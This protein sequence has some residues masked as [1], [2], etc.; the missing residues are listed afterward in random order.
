MKIALQLTLI[1]IGIFVLNSTSAQSTISG[2]IVSTGGKPIP[3]ASVYLLNTIDGG[4]TDS[5]GLFS[6]TTEEKGAQ[7]IVAEELSYENGGKPI[8][9]NGDVTGIEITLKL[10]SI[11]LKSVTV[12]AGSFE[13]SGSEGTILKPLD[14]VTTAGSQADVVK[15]IQTL[16]GTQQQGAQTGLFVRGGDASEAAVIIDGMV[17]QNAFLSAAPG[18][19]A[20]SRFGPFQFKGVSFSSGGYSARYGQA[21][22]SVLELNSNDQPDQSTINTGIN[23]AGVY[24]A[25]AK[26]MKKSSIEGSANYTNL[27]P[28][29]GIAKTNFDFYDVPKGGGGSAKYTY[30]PNENGIFKAMVNY[31]QFQNGT[32]VPN[33]DP[34]DAN[35]TLD[36]GLKN[37]NAYSVVSYKQTWKAKWGLYAAGMYSYNQ[38]DIKFNTMPIL[39]KDDRS[40]VRLEGKYFGGTKISVLLGTEVQHFKYDR[41]I[42][43]T[44][45]TGFNETQIAGYIEAEWNP[46]YWLAIKP[47]MR[48][49]NSAIVNQQSVSP[50]MAAAL[51]AGEHGQFSLASG[52]F[53]QLADPVYYII[54]MTVKPGLQQSVHYIANYQ[55]MH[56]DRTLRLEAYYK[57]YDQLVREIYIGPKESF[58]ANVNRIPGPSN[59]AGDGYAQ[60]LELFWRDKKTVKNGDYWISYS[61]IDTRRLYKNYFESV[62][63]DFIATHNL[64]IVTKYFIQKW[65]TQ[66][67]ATYNYAS[68]RP[69]YNPA[70]ADFMGDRAPDFHNLSITINY[71][72]S[73]GKWFS[74]IYAGVDNITNSKNVFGYR[75]STNPATQIVTRS[76]IV[77]P[78]YRSVF[79]GVNFSLTAFDVDEL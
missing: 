44:L 59:N 20:R 37:M 6:F 62:Q 51:R 42:F 57:S 4:T 48:V 29:Y 66:I 23:M 75:Y 18:V 46:L 14:I 39:N 58:D 28:F 68:G 25:A 52:I 10:S 56:D 13:A 33:P 7:T 21:L 17:A 26:L 8:N 41:T 36:F 70:S 40:Q 53:Y 61:Y 11:Q 65:A 31:Q 16:P 9:I 24:F 76:P 45:K 49:E 22:S 12:T 27:T 63:P 67:N 30:K 43:D 19:A 3:G 47:G 69:Y 2:R 5:S 15:A 73:F 79:V 35:R 71:L 74:V 77:P 38:D 54:P 55:Y 72:R 32:R 78:I 64:N 50:R 1:T 60:G 34:M